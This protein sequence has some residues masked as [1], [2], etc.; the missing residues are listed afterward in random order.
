M[1][2]K[3]TKILL[4]SARSLTNPEIHHY[5]A[6]THPGVSWYIKTV[7]P[8]SGSNHINCQ[9]FDIWKNI[10][11]KHEKL[12]R[13]ES[14]AID[15]YGN[16][17]NGWGTVWLDRDIDVIIYTEEKTGQLSYRLTDYNSGLNESGKNLLTWFRDN[18]EQQGLITGEHSDKIH[19]VAAFLSTFTGKTKSMRN[20]NK[21]K[22]L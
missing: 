17:I 11:L 21:I 2:E 22:V 6:G 10:E 20:R 8:V 18:L 7:I 14:T 5:N 13:I 19:D 4:D 12:A 9:L 16:V 1:F 15:W 3:E